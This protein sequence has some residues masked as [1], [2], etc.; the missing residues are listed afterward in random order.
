[1]VELFNI[2]GEPIYFDIV[3]PFLTTIQ[4]HDDDRDQ[5]LISDM[6]LQDADEDLSLDK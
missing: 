4:P 3:M 2:L 6:S 5:M 1:M